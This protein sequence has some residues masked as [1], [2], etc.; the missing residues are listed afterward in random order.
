M[1]NIAGSIELQFLADLARLR[2]DMD[3]AK[4]LVGNA[5]KEMKRAADSVKGALGALGVG[6]SVAAFAGWIKSAIDAG[7]AT[8]EFSQKTGIAVRDVAGL[9]LAFRQ[10]GVGGEELGKAM[11][12]LGKE[13]VEGN[14]AFKLLGVETRNADGTLRSTKAV[15]YDTADA[16]A[17]MKDGAAKATIAQELFAKGGASLIPTLN[18]GS[19]GLKEMADMAERMSLVFDEETVQAADKFNDTMDLLGQ[20]TDGMG[21][22]VAAQLLPTLNSLAGAMLDAAT[23]GDTLRKV[24]DGI[25]VGMKLVFTAAAGGAEVFSTLGKYIGMYA[26]ALMALAQGEFRQAKEIL[27]EGGRDIVQGWASTAKTIESAWT[28]AGAKTVEQASKMT[29]SLRTLKLATKE[30]EDAERKRREEAEKM[31]KAGQAL[32]GNLDEELAALNARI[33]LG[34]DLTDG[35]KDYAKAMAQVKDGKIGLTDAERR[36]LQV[37]LEHRDGL[38]R[39][40]EAERERLQTMAAVAAHSGRLQQAQATETDKLRESVVAM[41]EQNQTLGMSARE[42]AER[43][44]RIDESRAAELEWQAAMEG[45]NWQLEEQARLLRERAQLSREGVVVREAIEARNEWKKVTDQIG[46]GLTD[47]LYRAFESGKGFFRTLW[48]GIKNTFKTTVLRLVVDTVMKP[49]NGVLGSLLGGSGKAMAGGGG[50]GGGG[51]LGGLG[52][53]LGNLGSMAGLGNLGAGVNAGF[54]AL[55]GEAGLS[56]AVDAGLT[57]LGAG[58]IGGGLGTL[59]GSLGPYALAAIAIYSLAKKFDKRTPHMGSVVEM[60]STGN[61]RT[62]TNDASGITR[63]YSGEVDQALKLLSAGSTGV[64]NELSSSFGLRGGFS[65]VAKFA[66]DGKDASIGDFQL[67]DAMGQMAGRVIGENGNWALY[68]NDANAA[69]EQFAGDVARETLAAL[70]SLGLPDWAMAEINKLRVGATIDDITSVARK[71]VA[72]KAER[73]EAA[74]AS[75]YDSMAGLP[76]DVREVVARTVTIDE[77]SHELLTEANDRLQAVVDAATRGYTATEALV[78]LSQAGFQGMQDR[79]GAAVAALDQIAQRAALQDLGNSGSTGA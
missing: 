5:A 27:K 72:D 40:I 30:Q 53:M 39:Q 79:L 19:Q 15:L 6:L 42:L 65:S 3:Q 4:G 58:N 32:L 12:K 1:S 51:G 54:S 24:S 10:G 14:K 13:M 37:K 60:G 25:A 52:N 69:Y 61:L 47:S 22:R 74:K 8:K 48:E 64:L 33:S 55:F 57:A 34:R 18:E 62:L 46:Q 77:R 20:V 29:G 59:A 28:G 76:D 43:A 31:A 35:E 78:R 56:G 45:G 26:G 75:S 68:S 67:R 16:F 49:V 7:D 44:A 66:A 2:Q 41:Q 17:G 38:K 36:E 23:E 63:N 21:R 73:D 70:K 11:S 9:Q 71:I 50:G